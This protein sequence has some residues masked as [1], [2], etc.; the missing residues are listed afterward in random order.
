[1][2]R[3]EGV[4]ERLL[5][6]AREEFLEKGY[7]AASLRAI[8]ER[9]GSSKGA[10]YVRYADKEALYAAVVD[11]VIEE[12]ACSSPRS[13]TASASCPLTCSSLR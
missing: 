2:K 10:I 8:A 3:I 7:E 13:S 1:M 5:A 11:P 6:A 12:L 4:T 9:A